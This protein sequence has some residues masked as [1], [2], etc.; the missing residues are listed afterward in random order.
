MR[1]DLR[2]PAGGRG[3]DR[4]AGGNTQLRAP[5][6]EVIGADLPAAAV[7]GDGEAR[8]DRNI[9]EHEGLLARQGELRR[10][11]LQIGHQA[12]VGSRYVPGQSGEHHVARGRCERDVFQLCGSSQTYAPGAARIPVERQLAHRAAQ[13]HLR[14]RQLRGIPARDGGDHGKRRGLQRAMRPGGVG[15]GVDAQ[16]RGRGCRRADLERVRLEAPVP[17]EP[18]K[19]PR[20]AQPLDG[21]RRGAG[22]RR[23]P[24][25]RLRQHRAVGDEE[26]SLR[27]FGVQLEVAPAGLR[28]VALPGRIFA[29]RPPAG[30]LEHAAFETEG[31]ARAGRP[32]GI[33]GHGQ[34]EVRA[35]T[36][37]CG[38]QHQRV[39]SP[40]RSPV[41]QLCV[42]DAEREGERRPAEG[43]AQRATLDVDASVPPA[44]QQPCAGARQRLVP[45][46]A[47]TRA[48]QTCAGPEIDVGVHQRDAPGLEPAA[49]HHAPGVQSDDELRRTQQRP[50]PAGLAERDT[51]K[52]GFRTVPAPAHGKL[53]EA[54][55]ESGLLA[56]QLLERGAVLRHARGGQLPGDQ[57]H[58]TQDGGAAEHPGRPAQPGARRARSACGGRGNRPGSGLCWRYT[59][60]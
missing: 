33:A 17:A 49:A 28:Q 32:C 2:L 31:A 39:R 4:A 48:G 51:V 43:P 27:E 20:T 45:G 60:S 29:E 23:P 11:R 16:G 35:G 19:P 22:D 36:E 9:V 24:L 25:E 10:V 41:P 59:H 6:L 57:H 44:R 37:T 26:A 1:V 52:H 55:V 18:R 21:E 5:D 54:H 3:A 8:A 47:G 50:G 42:R 14:E 7:G 40:R 56:D 58:R 13:G 12:R 53:A 15:G 30:E 46:D 38:Q 34:G